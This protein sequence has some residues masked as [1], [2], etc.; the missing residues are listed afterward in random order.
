MSDLDTLALRIHQTAVEHGFWDDKREP[1]L[2]ALNKLAMAAGTDDNPAMRENFKVVAN[3]I[4]AMQVR[5]LG[6]MLMLMTSELAEALESDRSGE[7]N[8]W[9]RHT[10]TCV[11]TLRNIDSA[12]NIPPGE[13]DCVCN[14][15]PEGALVEVLDCVIRCLDTAQNMASSTRFAI[16]EVTEMKMLYNARREFMHGKAY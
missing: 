1:A 7:A 8:V 10:S 16:A 6:E 12:K 14:A 5:N 3:Y 13:G 4:T 9:F 11:E 15:K 2:D